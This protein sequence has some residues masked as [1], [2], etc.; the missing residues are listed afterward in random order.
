MS[1]VSL[2]VRDHMS[3]RLAT[4]RENQDIRE[5]VK[6]FTERNLFGGAVVDNRGNLVGILSVTDCI[7]VALRSGYHSGWRGTV[8]D[9]MSRDIRTVDADDSILA[10]ANMFMNDHY[11]RYPV[12]EDNRVVGVI[13]RLDVLKAL[14]KVSESGTPV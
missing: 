5:A 14:S 6:I 2:S 11:R 12:V 13:T 4:L 10:V 7:D 1:E 3:N 8:A 9:R